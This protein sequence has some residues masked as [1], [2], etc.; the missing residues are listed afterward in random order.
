MRLPATFSVLGTRGGLRRLVVAYSAYDLVDMA[1]WVAIIFYAYDVGGVSLVGVVAVVQLI[2]AAVI[3][4]ALVGL[5]D[6]LPRRTSLAASYGLVAATAAA[7]T[8]AIVLAA[9]VAAVV[10]CSTLATIAVAVARP[11]HFAS[12]PMAS[13]T[14]TEL[15]SGNALS[16]VA[17]GCALFLGPVAAGVGAAVAGPAL[18]L[19][20]SSAL[21]VGAT[22]LTLGLHLGPA[23]PFESADTPSWR[24]AFRGLGTLWRDWGALALLLVMTTRFVLGGATDVLGVAYSDDVLGLGE[25]AAG[26]IIGAMGIG[27]IVG[28]G[29]AG[30]LGARRRLAPVV[31]VS[32]V[33]QGVA[34]GAVVFFLLLAPAV[35][36]LAVSGMAAAIMMVAGRTLLQ[37]TTDEAVLAR[38]FAVQESTSLLGVAFGAI[39]APALVDAMSPSNAFVPFGLAVALLTVACFPLIRR[40]DLRAV[41][42]P[43]EIALLR[44]IPFLDALPRYEVEQLSRQAQWM[45]VA[46]GQVVIRQGDV[47]DRFY[48][49][50]EGEFTVQVDGVRRPGV[51][52]PGAGFGEVALL[53][54][55][56]RTATVTALTPGRL[57]T[58]DSDAFLAAV[59]GSPDGSAVAREVSRAYLELDRD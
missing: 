42:R 40:L 11:F 24:G 43:H 47:G 19:G 32:G 10:A 51:L 2:P 1:I 33:V 13:R 30:M 21:A 46:P 27:G 36:A 53:H 20:L 28:G 44:A 34:F 3:G 31:L 22:L 38:V 45:D 37:R 52:G 8:L 18:V 54:A 12:I 26:L 48:V 39:I 4:P 58:V 16:S 9:P 25:S 56:P 50:A 15:V 5:G 55:V 41:F 57:L 6:R 29:V 35:V 59:T 7:T 14:P 23:A 49:V 17:D